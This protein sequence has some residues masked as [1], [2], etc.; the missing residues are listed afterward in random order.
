MIAM[1]EPHLKKGFGTIG[2][3][4]VML[5]MLET[6]GTPVKVCQSFP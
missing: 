2:R 1:Y 5:M 6:A 4:R 3:E